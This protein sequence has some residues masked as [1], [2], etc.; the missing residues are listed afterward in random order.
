[1]AVPKQEIHE[2]FNTAIKLIGFYCT[3]MHS[4]QFNGLELLEKTVAE[5]GT[6]ISRLSNMGENLENSQVIFIAN[7][8]E[9]LKKSLAPV[10]TLITSLQENILNTLKTCILRE[11]KTSQ[12]TDAKEIHVPMEGFGVSGDV[13]S[14]KKIWQQRNQDSNKNKNP[15]EQQ[16]NELIEEQQQGPAI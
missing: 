3:K 12:S 13:A 4:K 9:P 2:L 5:L 1:M 15:P 7:Q 10:E 14:L 8:L 6:I 16:K 11:D